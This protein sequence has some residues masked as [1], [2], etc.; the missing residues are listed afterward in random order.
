M[1]D[2]AGIGPELIVKALAEGPTWHTCSPV[3]IGH[4]KVM[5]DICK[6]VGADLR[7]RVIEELSEASFSPP[8]V[9]VLCP[10]GL[11][12]GHVEWGKLNPAMGRAA[13]L[14]LQRAFETAM[15]NEVQGVVSAP[16]NKEALHLAGYEYVDDLA[17]L[18]DL[19]GSQEAFI[20][21]VLGSIWTVAVTEHIPFRDIVNL[22]KKDRILRY[23][24]RMHDVLKRVGFAEPRIAVAALNVHTGEGG[25]FGREEIEEI[26]PAVE[27][28]RVQGFNAEGPVAADTVFVRALAGD[29]DGVVC[30]YHD[31]ANIVRKLQPKGKSATLYMGLPVMCGTTAHGIAFDKAGMGIADPGSLK[32]ALRYTVM[33]SSMVSD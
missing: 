11:R 12:I 24:N 28:S 8:N 27:E 16:V 20:L 14:C 1:G 5:Q 22:I 26:E 30:M 9:D 18:A 2:A 6:V 13:A 15:G 3:V 4:P 33:L 17:Y 25:L 10:E 23:I 31:Q 7:F 32:A 29:F 21:G 19:T